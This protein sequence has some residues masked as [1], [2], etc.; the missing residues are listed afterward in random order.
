MPIEYAPNGEF[1]DYVAKKPFSEELARFYLKQL[2]H[3]IKHIHNHGLCHKDLKLENVLFDE[4]FNIK[5]ADF[6]FA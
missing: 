2:V 5:I 4:H 3:G 1:F 6:G